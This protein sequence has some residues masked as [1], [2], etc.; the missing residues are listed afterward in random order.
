MWAEQAACAGETDLFFG[1]PVELDRERIEREQRALLVCAVCPVI[2]PCRDHARRFRESGIW[3]GESEAQRRAALR[4]D[5]AT[6]TGDQVA[7]P[8]VARRRAR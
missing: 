4:L 2:E 1:S 5:K 6:S 7:E 3:G 8:I